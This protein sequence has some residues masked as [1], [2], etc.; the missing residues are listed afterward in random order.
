MGMSYRRAWL[1]VKTMNSCFKEPLVDASKGGTQGG[2]ARL[3][4]M[5]CDV[6]KRYKSME[7][8]AAEA[9]ASELRSFMALMTNPPDES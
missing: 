6:L 4:P 5:G 9:V 7:T 8:L 1:L 2:G 3:T